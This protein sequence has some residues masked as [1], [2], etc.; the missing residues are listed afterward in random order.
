LQKECNKLVTEGKLKKVGRLG[1]E[2]VYV[3][4]ETKYTVSQRRYLTVHGV[5]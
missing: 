4:P 3:L 1:R 2:I 5:E